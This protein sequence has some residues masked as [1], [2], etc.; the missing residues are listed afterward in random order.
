MTVT[1][2]ISQVDYIFWISVDTT[3]KNINHS[4][5]KQSLKMPATPSP[6]QQKITAQT[7]AL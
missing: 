5:V 2:L 6:Q 3:L 7:S 4:I 1:D